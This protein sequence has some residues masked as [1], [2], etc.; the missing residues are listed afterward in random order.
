MRLSL[1]AIICLYFA[2][3]FLLFLEIKVLNAKWFSR[4]SLW[5]SCQVEFQIRR[6][7]L[8]LHPFNFQAH[9]IYFEVEVKSVNFHCE[10]WLC[11][12]KGAWI[13]NVM[14]FQIRRR[15]IICF[16]TAWF[17]RPSN[18]AHLKAEILILRPIWNQWPRKP[19]LRYFFDLS[20]IV[21]CAH[22]RS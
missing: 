8:K 17:F 22:L 20:S 21:N 3:N 14:R 9:G 4:T 11:G 12:V 10:I 5:S 6:V 18:F 1:N 16:E 7:F 13:Q 15:K 19:S 2:S